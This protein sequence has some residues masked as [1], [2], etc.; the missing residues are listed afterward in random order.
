MT[1][2]V[3][4]EPGQ[5][6]LAFHQPYGPYLQPMREHL[7]CFAQRGG[8]WSDH[9][10]HEIFLVCQAGKVMPKTYQAGG[11]RLDRSSVV[12]AFQSEAEAMAFRDRFYAIGADAEDKVEREM[13]RRVEKFAAREHAK[14]VRKIH[15]AFP[16]IFNSP[17]EARPATGRAA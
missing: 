4:I 13:F 1:P 8:G 10:A 2:L 17:K 7:E 3:H 11:S 14:A 15:L 5:W 12:A 16:D 6:V 9:R